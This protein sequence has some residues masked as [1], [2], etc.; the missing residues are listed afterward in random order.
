MFSHKTDPDLALSIFCISVIIALSYFGYN[1]PEP[2]VLVTVKA[3]SIF[4]SVV[5][6]ILSPST[7]GV[8]SGL[9]VTVIFSLVFSHLGSVCD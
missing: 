9:D 3:W 7:V 6:Y 1:C 5:S 4:N 2:Y 8:V